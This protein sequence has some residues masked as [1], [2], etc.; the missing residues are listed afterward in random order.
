MGG[1]MGTLTKRCGCDKRNWSRC[2]HPWHFACQWKG[3]RYRI[4]LD[5][6]VGRTL[7]GKTEAEAETDRIRAS[8]RAGTF[9]DQ[10]PVQQPATP[11]GLALD[12]YT[13]IFLERY[14]KARQKKSWRDDSYILKQIAAFVLPTGQR[15]GGKL[16][17]AVIEDDVEACLQSLK[18]RGRAASTLNKYLQTF[19][20]M[21]HWGH[22][23]G[24]LAT[25][26]IGP[27]TDLKREKHARRSRR[28]GP[29][30]EAQLLRKA[31]PRLYRLIVAALETGCRLGEL[32][33]L[34]WQDVDLKRREMTI[35][36]VN[37][38]TK[39]QRHIPISG[40]L[41]SVLSMAAHDAAGRPFGSEAFAFGDEIGRRVS[42]PKKA[43]E[44]AVLKAHGH[45]PQWVRGTHSLATP[46]RAAYHAIDLRFHDLRHEAGSRWLEAGMPL[47]HVK[48]LLGHASIATTDTY[49]NAGRIHLQESMKRV[50]AVRNATNLPHDTALHDDLSGGEQGD[51][52][53]K[54]LLN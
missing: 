20:S 19:R 11:D 28:L 9:S 47:H 5:Q 30:E 18:D 2:S 37:A 46:S 39:T 45:V 22:R 15:F 50:E 51:A 41:V 24:Y 52:E 32:L 54:S 44:T 34:Q 35:R 29:D 33:S 10:L 25:P 49:L 3:R 27:F 38:K 31:A 4:S 14:S 42:S 21:S 43:W 48:E 16:I 40:R 8:I 12:A 13:D 6:H 36:A 7:K 23:K 53:A 1:T 26:W 17:G